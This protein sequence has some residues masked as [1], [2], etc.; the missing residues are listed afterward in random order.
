MIGDN[1]GSGTWG[2]I[3]CGVGG[4]PYGGYFG[5]K[6]AIDGDLSCTGCVSADDIANGAVTEN[7]LAPRSVGLPHLKTVGYSGEASMFLSI[8]QSTDELEWK[9]AFLV[10]PY[11]G[12]VANGQDALTITNAGG[13]AITGSSTLGGS[14]STGTLGHPQYGVFGSSPSTGVR[15]EASNGP[16]VVGESSTGSGVYGQGQTGHGVSAASSGGDALHVFGAGRHGLMVE[17]ATDD[18]IH[19]ASA[20]HDGVEVSSAGWSGVYV[21]SAGFDALRVQ[22]AGQDGLRLFDGIGRDYIRAGDDGNLEFRV[23]NDGAAFADGG[24]QGAADF[25]ELVVGDTDSGPLEPGDVL[26]IGE[27]ADRTVARSTVPYST[28]VAG[29]YSTK[30]GFVG[31]PHPMSEPE[32]GEVPV[33]LV[34]IVPCKVSAENG[35]IRRG[36]LL[37]TAATPG[38]AMRADDPPPGTVVAKALQEIVSGAGVIE[39]LVSL[40]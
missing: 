10:L 7:R 32:P 31:S 22:S 20:S 35:P 36:D 3:A 12:A 11:T 15:G 23:T 17:Q 9:Q 38:H 37:V 39:V 13:A 28:L 14:S 2:C 5:G 19:V 24:W 25:A 26:V 33:A 34:G 16:G 18:G 4:Q 40:M 6:V 30:P 1:H 8:S 27:R 29:V 21:A